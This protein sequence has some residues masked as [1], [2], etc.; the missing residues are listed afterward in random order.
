MYRDLLWII[1]DNFVGSL[2]SKVWCQR[3]SGN[4]L[5][6]REDIV[7][8]TSILKFLTCFVKL[9]HSKHFDLQLVDQVFDIDST[10][11]KRHNYIFT[12]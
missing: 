5:P 9:H 12:L 10:K 11:N 8:I 6:P 1:F 3:F 7:L 4:D 2:F